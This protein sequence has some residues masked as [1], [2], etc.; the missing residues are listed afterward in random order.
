MTYR[1]C[2]KVSGFRHPA[3]PDVDLRGFW[4]ERLDSVAARTVMIL[5]DRCVAAGM[6]DQ[7]DP[8]R[9]VPAVRMPFHTRADGSPDTVNVQMFWDSDVAKVIEAAAYALYRKKNPDLEAK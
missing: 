1:E 2:S 7:I 3:V 4:G 6:F 5:Y 9:P 8:K